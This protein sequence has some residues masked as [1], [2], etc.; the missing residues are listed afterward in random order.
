MKLESRNSLRRL[1]YEIHHLNSLSHSVNKKISFI[2]LNER[3]NN[4]MGAS[5][6]YI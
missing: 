3:G 4:D 2:K 6:K 1:A 5:I